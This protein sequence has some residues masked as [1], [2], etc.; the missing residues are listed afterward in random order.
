M[1]VICRYI[2]RASEQTWIWTKYWTN[3]NTSESS[4]P[5]ITYF[6]VWLYYLQP[7]LK[8]VSFSRPE[9]SI[10]G[11]SQNV[12]TNFS[13]KLCMTS[14]LVF[15]VQIWKFKKT[16][17]NIIWTTYYK[18]SIEYTITDFVNI[19]NEIIKTMFIFN[20]TIRIMDPYSEAYV[21]PSEPWPYYRH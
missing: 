18:W 3:C 17:A 11:K 4:K 20:I 1:V 9:I 10:T 14:N 16:L 12:C 15:V 2:G 13:T 8:P 5:Q 19:M 6:S 21:L 7:C